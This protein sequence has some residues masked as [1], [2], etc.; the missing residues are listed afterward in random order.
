MSE[1]WAL[2][3]ADAAAALAS[4]ACSAQELTAAHLRRIAEHNPAINAYLHVDAA[5]AMQAAVASDERRRGGRALH[6]LDGVPV[7]IKDNIAVAGMPWTA[8]MATRRELIADED[9]YCVAKLRRAGAVI[10]GKLHLQE[11]ALGA[12]GDNPHYGAC[13]NPHRLG[14]S[15]GGSSSGSAAALAGHLCTLAL[16]SD[17]MGSVRI[18]AAYCGVVG[19]KPSTGRVSQRGLVTASRRLDQIGPM[20][21]RVR[22]LA[23]L[24]QQISGVDSHD[25]AS[26]SVILAHSER[27]PARLKIGVLSDLERHGVEPALAAAFERGVRALDELLP[28]RVEVHFDDYDFG[29]LRRAG[30]LL[31]EAEMNLVHADDLRE[32]PELFSPTLSAMLAWARGKS[33]VDLIQ[34]ERLLDTAV[35]K[36]RRLY[37]SVDVL[38]TPT[39]PQVAFAHGTAVPA[40]QADLTS[41]ANFAGIPALSLPLPEFVDGLPAGLQLLGPVGSDL[42]LLALGER[43]ERVFAG[44]AGSR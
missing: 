36:A 26:R 7:A 31:C 33:A 43:I 24:Y 4:S 8:G 16:G 10:L 44:V 5:G 19:L 38:L 2:G 1:L 9:A 37:T 18:P 27:A 3:G 17:S 29:R 15:P 25:P 21:R 42:Q 40:N 12:D 23:M 13:H 11:A 41:F 30:L 14:H 35:L 6:P 32:R 39:T 22:D 28:R 20:A 34:A